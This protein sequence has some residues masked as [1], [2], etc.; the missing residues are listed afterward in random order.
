M[1]TPD[2]TKRFP[3]NLDTQ[4]LSEYRSAQGVIF[5]LYLD[6]REAGV[7][8]GRLVKRFDHLLAQNRNDKKLNQ[9]TVRFREQWEKEADHLRGWLGGLKSLHGK[10][11]AVFSSLDPALSRAFLLP[12]PVRDRLITAD[13]PYTPPLDILASEFPRMLVILMDRD[14]TRLVEVFLGSAEEIDR[15]NTVPVTGS[16]ADAD[17][18]E[19]A[20][21]VIERAEEAWRE[22]DY[23]RL[24]IGGSD[25]P[26]T[27]L[28]EHLP[29]SL[30]DYLA[31]EVPLTA[32]SGIEEIAAQVQR[33]EADLDQRRETG[34]LADLFEKAKN[35]KG[36][37]LGLEQTLLNVRSKKVH[38]LIVEEDYHEEGGLC[39]NCGFLG[40]GEEG[41]CLI[42]GMAL[43]PVPDIIEVALSQVLE[44]GGE[45]DVLRAPD[46]RGSLHPYGSIGAILRDTNHVPVRDMS[47][48]QPM[49]IDGEIQYD[50]LHDEA[51][52]ESFP[53]S[54]PPSWAHDERRTTAAAPP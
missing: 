28:R 40:K 50:T 24:L 48:Q 44:Q 41:I 47:T 52:E 21:A 2:Q 25:E 19:Y 30:Q 14:S 12:V 7:S 26:L 35:G 51:I 20:R 45:I 22:N 54:D 16:Q 29:A 9:D 8:P 38:L 46:T 39:P 42:C 11:L 10:G 49:V 13:R 37:V 4:E 17:L 36:A 18:A 33:I 34:R 15:L 53:A 5:S 3:P 23:G 43:H 6:L 27:S 32:H 1:P 31:D